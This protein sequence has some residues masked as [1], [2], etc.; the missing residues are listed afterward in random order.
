MFKKMYNVIKNFT[1]VHY[2]AVVVSMTVGFVGGLNV[3]VS[4]HNNESQA[5]EIQLNHVKMELTDIKGHWAEDTIRWAQDV[6]AIDGYP[7]A[8][9]KP[10][11]EVTEAEFI[12]MFVRSFGIIPKPQGAFKHWA[13]PLYDF[14]K[15]QN[16]PVL[17]TTD[18]SFRDN[19]I[20]R[21][22]VAEIIV[23][24]NG[25]NYTTNEAIQYLLSVGYS[26][27]KDSATV[28]GYKGKDSLTRA[29]AAQFVK[30]LKDHGMKDLVA[31][32]TKPSNTNNIPSQATGDLL[33]RI[34]EIK[35]AVTSAVEER[36]NHTVR[37]EN[38]SIAVLVNGKSGLGGLEVSSSG[39]QDLIVL[40]DGKNSESISLIVNI[41]QAAGIPVEDSFADVIADA[42]KTRKQST[43]NAGKYTLSIEP[44]TDLYK[45]I[46]IKAK[47]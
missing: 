44:S 38:N 35:D 26:N 19:Y 10:D 47:Y 34:A 32:P 15:A 20:S 23:G 21:E 33:P 4:P 22:K 7:D 13:D 40:H 41:M 31:M 25:F 17:G 1:I 12:G 30:N 9:F 16:Y 18:F 39:G 27:G 43:I 37:V 29:E 45:D 14:A 2:V 6:G 8:T 5:A 3:N 42:V 46:S 28:E 11:R 36:P 24:A